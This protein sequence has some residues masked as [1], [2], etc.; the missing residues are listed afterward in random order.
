MYGR[1]WLFDVRTNPAFKSNKKYT[2]VILFGGIFIDIM[3]F[4]VFLTLTRS[5]KRTLHFAEKMSR[6]ATNKNSILEQRNNDLETLLHVTS[7]DLREPIRAIKNFSKMIKFK[8]K[9]LLD[10]KGKDLFFRIERGGQRMDL[11]LDDIL[12]LSHAQ[13]K[14]FEFESLNCNDIIKGVLEDLENKISENKAIVSVSEDLPII[15][16]DKVWVRR[17]F[18]NLI[19]NSLKFVEKGSKPEITVEPLYAE[20]RSGVRVL[21]RGMGIKEGLEEKIFDL[22]QRGVSQRVEGTGAGLAIVKEVAFRHKGK[23]WVESRKNGGSIFNILFLN[24]DLYN[25]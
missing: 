11:L 15:Y 7:H 6:E 5:N 13:R 22:F 25:E 2:F 23:V 19:G 24:K 3:L 20:G 12:H 10:E 4:L 8:Y 18:F 9:D 1:N 17:A 14:K 21:D 16:G